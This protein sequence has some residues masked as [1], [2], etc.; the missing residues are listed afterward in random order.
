LFLTYRHLEYANSDII[1]VF[2]HSSQQGYQIRLRTKKDFHL[3]GSALT[4]EECLWLADEI[5]N[6]M[7][8][9]KNK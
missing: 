5:L 1:G 2:L 6:W 8:F 3:L 4:E 7:N 9:V